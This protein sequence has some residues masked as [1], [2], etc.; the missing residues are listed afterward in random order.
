ML[1]A[2]LPLAT[3]Q[4]L[5]KAFEPA[6][7]RIVLWWLL[8]LT[9]AVALLGLRTRNHFYTLVAFSGV[10]LAVAYQVAGYL[11][12]ISTYPLSLG[13]SEAS[14]YYNASLFFA[15]RMYGEAVPCRSSTQAAT[16][17]RRCPS[18]SGTC[19][20]GSTGCGRC[21]CGSSSRWGRP[22]R[23]RAG[24][25]PDNR[26]G[27]PVLIGFCYLFLMQG[28]V[29]YHLLLSAWIVLIGASAQRPRRTILVVILASAW[30][31]ISRV[32][33]VSG[34]CDFGDRA[35]PARAAGAA[36]R[37]GLLTYFGW[38]LAYAVAGGAAL[39]LRPTAPMRRALRQSR[40]GV[41]FVLHVGPALVPPAPQRHVSAWSPA[42]DPACLRRASSW[43]S[44]G[45]VTI[46]R[47]LH[48][49]R[50]LGLAGALAVL[51]AGGLVVSAKIGGGGN[52]HN[53]DAY[54][55]LLLGDRR[56]RGLRIASRTTTRRPTA[57]W[58]PPPWL[59]GAGLLVPV[60]PCR[61][62]RGCLAG[63]GS[64]ACTIDRASIRDTVDEG[65][66]ARARRSCSSASAI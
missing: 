35:L 58:R 61:C 62:C 65:A 21:C 24:C 30:A 44:C 26:L 7:M 33:L 22:S 54:L 36:G 1:L 60:A 64:G 20:C 27:R 37:R 48:P 51:F 25:G 15:R 42:G 13:W 32:Q 66:R 18:S 47:G 16:C 34:P 43:S 10:A 12:S 31:G 5:T 2:V 40:C 50:W 56:L 17:C 63:S 57:R 9:G 39:P 23:W 52:L 59:F 29:Y 41:R 3:A 46:A 19:R 11:P 28:P 53:L 38:P 49:V 4:P 55:V 6:S 8:T 45:R 14:R